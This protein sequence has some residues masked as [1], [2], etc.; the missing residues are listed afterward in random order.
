M[1][2]SQVSAYINE[3]KGNLF[4]FLVAKQLATETN[5]DKQFVQ[6]IA[7][8]FHLQLMNYET[9][10]RKQAPELLSQLPLMAQDLTKLLK[11]KIRGK[12]KNIYLIGKVN[13]TGQ[14]NQ[15]K[16]ADILVEA[17]KMHPIS[18]KLSKEAAFVNTK[19]AGLKSFFTQYFS[20]FKQ[21]QR[22]QIELNIFIEREFEILSQ[23]LHLHAG[24]NYP[25]HYGLWK[26]A[27]YSELPGQLGQDQKMILH[28]Y[29]S[30]ITQKIFDFMKQL[31]QENVEAFFQALLP[32]MGFGHMDMI[33]A[34]CFY[35][36]NIFR[37]ELDELKDFLIYNNNCLLK[38]S[39]KKLSS[40]E[41]VFNTLTL[42]IRVKP[43]N[44]FTSESYKVN[45]SIKRNYDTFLSSTTSH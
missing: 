30:K 42:Q 27:G 32:L 5:L 10:L 25:G 12:I 9:Q 3:F 36:K 38:K 37:I 19:S 29:Y 33:Q 4:E 18:L 34:T 23:N 11:E 35:D 43:M 21:A 39:E 45:C 26:E 24:L 8:E 28:D 7:P 20:S 16:E 44:K 17:E 15:W 41:I 40:F 13:T 14:N 22:M 31:Q 1:Q 6:D 2:D